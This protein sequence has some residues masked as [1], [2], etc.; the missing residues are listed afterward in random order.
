MKYQIETNII[1]LQTGEIIDLDQ[2]SKQLIDADFDEIVQRV[3]VLKELFTQISGLYRVNEYKFLQMM[4]E[5]DAKKFVNDEFEIKLQSQTDYEY[6]VDCI[7]KLKELISKEDFEKIFTEQYK[8]N[9]NLLRTVY[10]LGGEIK[11]LI[12][13]MQKKNERKPTI[14]LKLK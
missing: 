11:Q 7:H 2:F 3:V 1:D 14:T 12:D 13:S 6:N 8:V 10:T 4:D 5:R 9:R